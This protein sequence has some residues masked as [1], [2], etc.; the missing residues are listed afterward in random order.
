MGCSPILDLN[1]PLLHIIGGGPGDTQNK[2][3][4]DAGGHQPVKTHRTGGEGPGGGRAFD[5]A[6]NTSHCKSPVESREPGTVLSV[7]VASC[8][9]PLGA[10]PQCYQNRPPLLS[11]P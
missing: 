4:G 5:T 1:H 2:A 6:A 9:E 8:E 7:Q 11:A 10:P 3:S